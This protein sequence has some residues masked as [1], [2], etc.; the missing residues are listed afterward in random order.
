MPEVREHIPASPDA[1]EPDVIVVGGGLAGVCA[2]ITAA[3]RGASVVVLDGAHGGGSSAISGG[4]IYA[5]GGTRQQQEAGYGGDTPE[6]M[7]RYLRE[8]IGTGV[9]GEPTLRRF[10]DESVARMEWLQSHGVSFGGSL[11]PFRTSYPT[12]RYSLY[13]SGNEKAYPFATVAQPAPRGHRVVGDGAGGMN[14]TGNVLWET[15]F[16]SAVQIGVKFKFASKVEQ[17]LLGDSTGTVHGVRYLSL[18]ESSGEFAKH[19][20]L[21]ASGSKYHQLSIQS[22]ASWYDKRADTLWRRNAKE[23]SLK[24]SAV[25]LSA[26]GF[27]M[28]E[29]MMKEFIPWSSRVSPLGTSGDDGSGIKLGQSVGGAVSHMHRM[30]A[31]RLMYPPEALVEGIVVSAKG[32]RIAAEDLYGASFSDVMIEKAN[33]CGYLIL[34]SRQWKGVNDQIVEQTQMPWRA[35]IRYLVY[36]AHKRA[37]S[38]G[39]LARKLGVDP[40][41]ME[42]TVTAYND[43]IIDGKPDPVNKLGWRSVINE[44]PFYGIDISLRRSG[45][46]VVPALP[47][48]GLKVEEETGLVLNK[49][50]EVIHGLYAAGK[51]AVGVCSNNYVSGLAL[52]DCVFSGKRAGGHVI[53]QHKVTN[54]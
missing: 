25:I 30:S 11:C 48:G 22:L 29:I 37:G 19:R 45:M 47:L 12:D 52:A 49:N 13:F 32:E 46:L 43:A 54:E 24:A 7:F 27:G 26:G 10:C 51:N 16:N 36:W 44:G 4:V 18:D 3:E 31:W 17:L 23:K 8:E 39:G 5:G 21:K 6:N 34:D 38:L 1:A 28:N 9:V 14:M 2:A 33:G 35:F 15:M 50:G 53:I 42:S 41:T 20:A 40:T